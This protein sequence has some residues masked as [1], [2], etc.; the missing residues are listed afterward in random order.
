MAKRGFVTE[1][2]FKEI[3]NRRF[4]YRQANAKIA[5]DLG[6]CE[7]AV[8]NYVNVYSMMRDKAFDALAGYVVKDFGYST[9]AIKFSAN[10][11]GCEI[12]QVVLDAIATRDAKRE[13]ER[14]PEEAPKAAPKET[15][16]EKNENLFLG[17]IIN[18]LVEQNELLT[19]FMDTV[20][21]HYAADVKDNMNANTDVICER[22]KNCE[23]SL[24]KIACNSRKRGL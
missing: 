11:L 15:P 23:T 4:V 18:L 6:L 17:K 19:Q 3:L 10:M 16:S 24:D 14:H 2:V 21:P 13:K 9:K 12:P 7:S 1:E 22:L 20:L 5:D 8:G